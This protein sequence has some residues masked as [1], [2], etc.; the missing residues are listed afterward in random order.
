MQDAYLAL[1]SN[2]G[3]RDAH[4][5]AAVNAIAALPDTTLVQESPVY[6]TPPMGPQDQG[7][8]LNSVIQ[9][10]TNIEPF[11]LVDRLQQIETQ[12]GRASREERQHWGPRI[13]DIDIVLYGNQVIDK[14]GLTIPHP[15]MHERWFVLKPLADIA[16]DA[17]HPLLQR[18]VSQLL[19]ALQTPET[20]GAAT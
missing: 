1:G 20:K 13:I 15:G 10:R 9:I 8:Y 16:P 17:V 5:N 2:L 6:D 12:L 18:T 7:A 11:T 4:L 14:P 19:E 3:D